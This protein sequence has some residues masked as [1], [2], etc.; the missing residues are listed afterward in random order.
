MYCTK[1]YGLPGGDP[2]YN[3]G[4]RSKKYCC[5]LL[6]VG[7]IYCFH[8]VCARPMLLDLALCSGLL[9]LTRLPAQCLWMFMY[10]PCLCMTSTLAFSVPAFDQI[11]SC[12]CCLRAARRLYT[13]RTMPSIASGPAL[14]KYDAGMERQKVNWIADPVLS[15]ACWLRTC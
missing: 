10:L 9:S 13:P 5:R 15:C 11:L 14:Q 4:G 7:G 1:Y 3:Y 8:T 6:A 2:V 12:L